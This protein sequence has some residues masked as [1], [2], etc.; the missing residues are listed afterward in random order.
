MFSYE[1]L[2]VYN[3][4]YQTNQKVYRLVKSNN[5]I[6]SYARQQLGRAS[7]SV[8]LNIAEGSA[9]FSARS[10]RS[11]FTTARASAFECASLITFL[12]DEGEISEPMREELYQSFEEISILLF[13]M[14]QNL[15]R[16][17]SRISL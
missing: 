1:K 8:M 13:G 4:A 16:R 9:T 12:R 17:S 15:N 7:L 5:S 14:V 10:R 6:A 2:A 3:K 11:F